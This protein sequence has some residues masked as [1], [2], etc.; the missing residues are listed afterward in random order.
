MFLNHVNYKIET[1]AKLKLE[2]FL[3]LLFLF[4]SSISFAQENNICGS[5]IFMTKMHELDPTLADRRLQLE[6][7]TKEYIKDKSA[8]RNLVTYVIPVVVHIFHDNGVGNIPDVNVHN[9]LEIVNK[10]FQGN[11]PDTVAVVDAF[12]TIIGGLDIEFRLAAKDPNGN[13]TNGINRINDPVYTYQGGYFNGSYNGSPPLAWPNDEYLNIWVV[14]LIDINGEFLGY[15]SFPGNSPQRDGIV[16]QNNVFGTLPPSSNNNFSGR[17]MSHEIG[18]FF[19]LCHIWCC[20]SANGLPSNC[21]CDD[22]VA[23]TPNTVGTTDCNLNNVSCGDLDNVQNLMDYSYGSCSAGLMFTVGQANRM[24]AALNSFIGGRNNLWSP[25][26]LMSTGTDDTTYNNPVI[27]APIADFSASQTLTCINGNITFQDESF[28]ADYDS[29]W[30][31]NWSFPGAIPET[32]T[33]RNPVV[34]YIESGLHDVTLT[35]T[36]SAGS[37]QPL[38]KSNYVEILLGSESFQA[39]YHDEISDTWPDDPDP[40]LRY[41]VKSPTGTSISFSRTTNAFY[42]APQSIFLDNFSYNNSGEHEFI[43]P[44]MDLTDMISGSTY[45]N[46]QIAYSKK[47]NE[48]EYIT[49]YNSTDC[50]Q[51]WNLDE[52]ILSTSFISVPNSNSSAFTPVDTSEWKFLSYDIS[53]FA[54]EQNVQ[55]SF[56]FESKQGNNLY[57]DDIAVSDSPT[58]QTTTLIDNVLESTFNLYPNPNSGTFNLDFYWSS[59]NSVKA[60]IVDLVGKKI[61]IDLNSELKKGWNSIQV[62]IDEFNLRSGVYFLKLESNGKYLFEK[63]IIK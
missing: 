28:N 20:N 57:I 36:N 9:M 15:S 40:T 55:F 22:G 59:D 31:Y 62:N 29:T 48:S 52:I 54:G 10:D 39:P 16:I 12:K 25:S 11:Q 51:T 42:S 1:M 18:H 63:F 27:C 58:P 35:V 21:N 19:N 47:A 43:T 41:G 13:C 38:T 26:N 7:F 2:Y 30:T 3:L 61:E 60:H 37:S 45:L 4:S 23:D 6:N 14:N 17:Y 50:G 56:R 33:D 46:F 49:I 53:D 34:S 5:D 24:D 32:S 44:S 8:N